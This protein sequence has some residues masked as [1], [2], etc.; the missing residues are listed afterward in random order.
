MDK[1]RNDGLRNEARFLKK[2]GARR[3]PRSGG[4]PGFPAD[5]KKG[6]W[7]IEV[8]SPEGRAVRVE[9]AWLAKIEAAALRHDKLP[10][11]ALNFVGKAPQDGGAVYSPVW[12]AVPRW[13]FERL[14]FWE[15]KV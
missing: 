4:I 6:R 9:S 3:Q 2:V 13:L 7:L 8:K 15:A 5:G 12:L 1:R 14:G 10:L 11:L